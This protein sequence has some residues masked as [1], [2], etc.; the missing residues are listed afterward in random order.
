MKK[1]LFIVPFL[2]LIQLQMQAQF[3]TDVT[4]GTSRQD[5]A[6]VNLAYRH[7][8]SEKFRAGLELQTGL[9]SYRFIGAKVIDEGVSI[10]VSI[11]TLLR[12]YQREDFRI[13]LYSRLGFR[14]QSVSSDYEEEEVLQASNSTGFNIEPGLAVTYLLSDRFSVQSGVTLPVLFEMSPEF[15]MENNVTN[16]F[17]NVSYQ[18]SDCSVFLLKASTGPAAGASGDSQKYL[19]SVQAG[20]RFLFGKKDPGVAIIPEPSF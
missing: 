8:F 20:L 3:F 5:R 10:T 6:F 7:Q 19:W 16:L 9:V 14:F 18:F 4:V 11:P 15:L 17:A 12:F 1:T 13:D 2:C